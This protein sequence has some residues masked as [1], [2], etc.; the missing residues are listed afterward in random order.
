MKIVG[1]EFTDI[2]D[3]NLDKTVR[4]IKRNCPNDGNILMH[5][6]LWSVGVRVKQQKLRLAN[7]VLCYQ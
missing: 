1:I 6:H 2:S 5:A 3:R 7:T 4:R